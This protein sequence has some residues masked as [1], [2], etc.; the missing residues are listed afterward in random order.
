MDNQK[1]HEIEPK[2]PTFKKAHFI[3]CAGFDAGTDINA[4]NDRNKNE[5]MTASCSMHGSPLCILKKSKQKIA[6]LEVWD[7]RLSYQ[8]LQ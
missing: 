8:K 6:R 1:V 3:N 5:S 4:V 7:H 2:T